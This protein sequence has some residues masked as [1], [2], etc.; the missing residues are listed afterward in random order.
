MKKLVNSIITI[1]LSVC[2]CIF[3]CACGSVQ[4]VR[5]NFSDGVE[6]VVQDDT[7]IFDDDEKPEASKKAEVG[8]V[9]EEDKVERDNAVENKP[10]AD[11]IVKSDSVSDAQED[12]N[13]DGR[14]GA[15]DSD[16]T[17]GEL[18]KIYEFTLVTDEDGES[19][20][21]IALKESLHDEVTELVIPEDYR[22]LPVKEIGPYPSFT[23]CKNLTSIIIPKSI[24]AIGS[25]AFQGCEKLTD[26]ILPD[27]LQSIGTYAFARCG[28]LT[29][30]TLP[31]GL[32]S[33]ES[34]A[35]EKCDNL[36]EVVF[37]ESLKTIGLRTF[38]GCE[39]LSRL[40][41]AE[42]LTTIGQMAFYYCTNLT[43]VSFPE[44]LQTIDRGAFLYCESITQITLPENVTTLNAAAFT[45]CFALESVMILGY[46][47]TIG[48][49][50]FTNCRNLTE[51]I[52][53]G[54]IESIAEGA[55][56]NCFK[57]EKVILPYSGKQA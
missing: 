42:G 47:V 3:F 26:L 16:D 2:M 27:G 45:N 37:P 49:S 48:T 14:A 20:Y 51:V 6:R 43:D 23:Y 41:F 56:A 55:F 44:S 22:G 12:E 36:E 25:T 28:S 57:L 11:E 46:N 53:L 24:Q 4:T 33:L 19:Y 32:V 29:S 31:E 30:V 21:K 54:S 50:A 8:A 17:D 38:H 52:A 10:T 5:L 34:Y 40:S 7:P 9:T 15:V 18:D 13:N 35:F 1:L 39:K